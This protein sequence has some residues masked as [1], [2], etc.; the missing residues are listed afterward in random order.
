MCGFHWQVSSG[1]RLGVC[2]GTL[3]V[4]C[5]CCEIGTTAGGTAELK[6]C[7]DE[8][9]DDEEEQLVED[10]ESQMKKKAKFEN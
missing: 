9:D 1:G 4:V 6:E 7:T 5:K 8:A 2:V 3:C 10:R